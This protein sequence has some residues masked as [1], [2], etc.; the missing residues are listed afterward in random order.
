MLLKITK[1]TIL[2]KFEN[3]YVSTGFK[4]GAGVPFA[5]KLLGL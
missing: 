1:K 5:S 3:Q 4:P 2:L